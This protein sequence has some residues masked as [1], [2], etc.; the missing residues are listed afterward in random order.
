MLNNIILIFSLFGLIFCFAMMIRNHLVR[1]RKL[2][3]L[4]FIRENSTTY[5]QYQEYI[6]IYD[7]ISYDQMLYRFWIPVSS[8]YKEYLND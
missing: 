8:Y 4:D 1:N 5:E 2:K 7:Q 3:F 6:K